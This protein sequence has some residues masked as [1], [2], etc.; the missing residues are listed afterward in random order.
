VPTLLSYQYTRIVALVFFCWCFGAADLLTAESTTVQ[1]DP[2]IVEVTVYRDRA[3]VVKEAT[4][5]LSPGANSVEFA[6]LPFGVEQDTL[7]VSAVGTPA[8]IGAIEVRERADEPVKTPEWLAA[9]AEVRRIESE[10]AAIDQARAV[11]TELRS[12]LKSVGEVTATTQARDIGDGRGDPA[13]IGAV[14]TLLETKLGTLGRESLDRGTKR[15]ELSEELTVAHAR[16]DT[17]RPSG[18]IRSRSAIVEVEAR[19]S[20]KLTLRL[21]YLAPGSSWR[22]SYRAT[23]DAATGE[24]TLISEGVVQQ[25]TGEDWSDI[26][27]QL[28]SASPSVGVEPPML[29]SWVLRPAVVGF[30]EGDV[31]ERVVARAV[32]DAPVPGRYYQNVLELA[33]GIQDGAEPAV[34][35]QGTIIRSAYNVAFRVPGVSSVPADG[36]DHRVVLV[37]QT[38]AANLVH[39]TVPGLE[40]RAYLT[41]VTT[42]PKDYPLLAGRVRAFVGG[43]YL[44]SFPLK[45]TGPGVELTLPFG[46]DNR[47]EIVRVPE[48]QMKGRSGI[49]GRYRTVERTHRTLIHNL[50]GRETTLVLE[51]RLPVSEDERIEVK[52]GTG[53]T[54]GFKDSP[55]RPGVKLWTLTLAAGEERELRF[56]YSVKYPRELNLPALVQ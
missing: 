8:T 32:A 41:A 28:S 39:R 3:E 37:Q 10:I 6:D 25:S 43:A 34:Q 52:L 51:E 23:L 13:T 4:V 35:E 44:G 55:R 38:L 36:S 24:V 46:I 21:A 29:V 48:P 42:S 26:Q 56:D 49:T 47:I 31:M 18:A 15:R 54:P 27:L 11:G 5:L 16:L 14:Y 33:P 50:L 45:D 19:S 9:Q 22:P 1:A 2:R 7:R 30:V 12:F 40:D 20:G 53:T 17:L